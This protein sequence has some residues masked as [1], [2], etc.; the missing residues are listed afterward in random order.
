MTNGGSILTLTYY[1]SEKVMPHYNVMGLA[2]SALESS[3]RYLAADLGEN[4][5]RVN[6]LSA[7]PI[8]TLAAS[9]IGDFRYILKWN[10]FNSP[11]RRN[12]TLDDV[13]GSAVYLLSNLSSGVSG[14]NHHVDC[15]Y[16]V[17]GMKAIDAP[18]M[19]PEKINK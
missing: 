12:V 14:E 11:L 8:K 17:V 13:G 7:G 15:G 4:N 18:D 3:V 16:H 9:G 19:S 10:E 5:I 6:S 1:G 2:K